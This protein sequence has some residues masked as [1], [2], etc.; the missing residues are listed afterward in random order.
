MK[1]LYRYGVLLLLLGC[2]A[3]APRQTDQRICYPALNESPP[4]PWPEPPP[5][6]DVIPQPPD[7]TPSI[8]TGDRWIDRMDEHEKLIKSLREY[9]ATAEPGDPFALTEEEISELSKREDIR[10]N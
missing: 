10:I 8:I 6:S 9:S 2:G 7:T 1:T 5:R 3:E 4:P